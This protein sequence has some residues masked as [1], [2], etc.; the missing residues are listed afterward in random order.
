MK[1]D[2]GN[3]KTFRTQIYEYYEAAGRH[4]LPWRQTD[5]PYLICVSELMLQQTQVSRVIPKYEQFLERFPTV[6]DLAAA[7]LGDVLTVWQGLGYN[8]RAKFLWQAAQQVV[9][10]YDG[11]FPDNAQALVAL[12]G[13][14]LNTAGAILAYAYDQPVVFI[15][16]NVR[17]VYIHHFFGDNPAVHDAEIRDVLAQT[18]DT[19]RPRIFYWALMDYGSYLKQTV[20]NK[21]VQSKHYA[22]QRPFQGSRRQVRGAIIRLLTEQGYTPDKLAQKIPDERCL[23][24]AT[25]LEGE[26]IITLTD[27]VYHLP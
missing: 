26:G 10:L 15:E 22:R 14:G 17:T 1:L 23:E 5:D 4:D 9:E 19:N 18:L 2:S 24:V 27:G 21:T 13:I 12:P 20:G 7:S 3:I 11:I 6:Q 25:E 16:T 8:R